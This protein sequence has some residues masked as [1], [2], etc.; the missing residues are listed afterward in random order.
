MIARRTT[1]SAVA[2][3][4][5]LA[6]LLAAIGGSGDHTVVTLLDSRDLDTEAHLPSRANEL[7]LQIGSVQGGCALGKSRGTW[8][9]SRPSKVRIALRV[10]GAA[11]RYNF[12][13]AQTIERPHCVRRQGDARAEGSIRGAARARRPR[14]CPA[15]GDR[16]AQPGDPPPTTMIRTR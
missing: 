1:D 3:S 14:T 4:K 13:D 16:S 5:Q 12:P 7:G 15:Q 10:A 9:S 8:V 2:P 6:S 11:R